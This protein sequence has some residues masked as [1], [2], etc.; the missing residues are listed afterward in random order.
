MKPDPLLDFIHQHSHRPAFIAEVE[1]CAGITPGTIL[2]S[3][4]VNSFIYGDIPTYFI[5]GSSNFFPVATATR[6]A[7][8]LACKEYKKTLTWVEQELL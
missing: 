8:K 2:G 3:F 6:D 1:K 7:L 5:Y 4:A